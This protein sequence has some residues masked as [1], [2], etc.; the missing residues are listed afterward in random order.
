[1]MGE[2]GE[3]I[4]SVCRNCFVNNDEQYVYRFFCEAL[5]QPTVILKNTLIDMRGT[6]VTDYQP[7]L[8]ANSLYEH[9]RTEVQILVLA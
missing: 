3:N 1:M 6:D 5:V 2:K 9:T 7:M 4:D 8:V